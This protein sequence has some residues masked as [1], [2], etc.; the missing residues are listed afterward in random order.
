MRLDGPSGLQRHDG[1]QLDRGS[2][3]LAP[4]TFG[5]TVERA[6]ESPA[7]A[8][9]AIRPWLIGLSCPADFVDDMALVVSEL[10]TN[11]VVHAGSGARLCAEVHDGRLR[12]EVD[13]ASPTPPAMRDGSVRVGGYGLR[14]VAALADDWGWTTTSCG[15]QVWSE[16][17][18]GLAAR[19]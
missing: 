13:D 15:K 8:R 5:L 9:A 6:P 14:L 18:F 16:H 4:S 1:T 3:R 2:P 17:R 19:R 11:A 7:T 10:V 12:L